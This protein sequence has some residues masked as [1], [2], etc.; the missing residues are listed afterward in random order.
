MSDRF[1]TQ[2]TTPKKRAKFFERKPKETPVEEFGAIETESFDHM[3]Q[4]SSTEE[5]ELKDKEGIEIEYDFRGAEVA[6]GLKIFQKETIY[7]RNL[8]YTALLFV[9]F[10][11]YVV[12]IVKDP[13]ETVSIFL[14]IMCVVVVGYIWLLPA[15]HIKRTAQAVEENHM[16]FRMT[17]YD[18]CIKIGEEKATYILRYNQEITKIYDTVKF[19]LICAGKERMFILPKRCLEDGQ[20]SQIK[21][22]FQSALE[23]NY[24]KKF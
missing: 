23:N 2:D 20:Y 11:L 18:T 5:E 3:P 4:L 8:I 14:A 10:V 22:L 24:I 19:F 21:P 6:E 1:E 7:K 17:V 16:K 9:I 13:S 15:N 12:G